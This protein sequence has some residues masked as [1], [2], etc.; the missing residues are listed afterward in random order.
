MGLYILDI[1]TCLHRHSM[2]TYTHTHTHTQ[3]YIYIYIYIYDV[4]I[5]IKPQVSILTPNLFHVTV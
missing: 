3:I 5:Y 2:Y 4:C 1:L